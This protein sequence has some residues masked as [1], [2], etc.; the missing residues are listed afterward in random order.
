MK[1]S[2]IMVTASLAFIAAGCSTVYEGKY[3]YNE[4][5]RTGTVEALNVDAVTDR[6]LVDCRKDVSASDLAGAKSVYVR[7]AVIGTHKRKIVALADH[8]TPLQVGD[9]VYLRMND[10]SQR[11]VRA[12]A[13]PS[14]PE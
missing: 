7:H 6:I 8:D 4:G 14:K 3:Q 5:W 12:T 11:L 2:V 13:V 9:K 10:C 1:I